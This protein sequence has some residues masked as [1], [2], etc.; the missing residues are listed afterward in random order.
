VVYVEDRNA[1][2]IN[3]KVAYTGRKDFDLG[4]KAGSLILP[5]EN[6][7]KKPTVS[8]VTFTMSYFFN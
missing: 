1:Q 2:V 5:L 6:V 7:D 8:T 3:I 4:I